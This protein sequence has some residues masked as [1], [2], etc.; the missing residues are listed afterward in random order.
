MVKSIETTEDERL[1]YYKYLKEQKSLGLDKRETLVEFIH[2]E[3]EEAELRRQ[4][5]LKP[6]QSMRQ[7]GRLN[8]TMVQTANET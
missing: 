2:R 5:G 6:T 8:E 1:R 4:K 7:L 3:R